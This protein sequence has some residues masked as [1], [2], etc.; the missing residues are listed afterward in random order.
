MPRGAGELWATGH[1]PFQVAY[2]TDGSTWT[3]EA[4]IPSFETGED[5]NHLTAIAF[6]KDSIWVLARD[7][8]QS[9]TRVFTDFVEGGNG[10]GGNGNGGNR[11]EPPPAPDPPPGIP[12]RKPFPVLIIPPR[13][14]ELP[15]VVD[16]AGLR[17]ALRQVIG[18]G[19]PGPVTTEE[20]NRRTPC[21]A[22]Q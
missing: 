8:G 10:N 7:A 4:T 16:P 20:M 12:A 3:E 19:A 15:T 22:P 6:W 2:S 18:T 9:N 21:V 1:D 11:G 5:T 17:L 13:P 14:P